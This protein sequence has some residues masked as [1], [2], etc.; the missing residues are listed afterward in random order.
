MD[1]YANAPTPSI[2]QNDSSWHNLL[3]SRPTSVVNNGGHSAGHS[4][5]PIGSGAHSGLGGGSG[6]S[7]GDDVNASIQQVLLR[8]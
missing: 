5:L 7:G 1:P 3:S 8:F 2:W 6:S 4:G